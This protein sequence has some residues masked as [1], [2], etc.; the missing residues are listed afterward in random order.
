MTLR[1]ALMDWECARVAARPLRYEVFVAEQGVPA[2]LEWDEL[3]AV[4][5]HALAF[6]AAGQ[7]VGTGRLLPDGH[8][9]RMA[10]RL[11]WRGRGVGAA[12]LAALLEEARR[13]GMARVLLHS[14]C[15]AAGFYRRFGFVTQGQEFQEA[16]I[17]HVTMALDLGAV[18]PGAG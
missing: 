17:A 12:L 16:G 5:L 4:S 10:V 7:A 13:R 6:D 11:P 8:V 15:R 1:V 3:D 9:G 18:L 2:E 14:Q